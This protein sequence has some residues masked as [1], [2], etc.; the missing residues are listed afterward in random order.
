MEEE[1]KPKKFKTT[2]DKAKTRFVFYLFDYF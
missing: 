1:K 2:K